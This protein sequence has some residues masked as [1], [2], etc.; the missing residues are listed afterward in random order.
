L[1]LSHPQ[2]LGRRLLF[3]F[4]KLSLIYLTLPTVELLITSPDNN[5]HTHSHHTHTHNRPRMAS[6]IQ[7]RQYYRFCDRNDDGSINE[8]SCYTPFWYTQ[9][10]C[11]SPY[12]PVLEGSND[13]VVLQTGVI[14][15]WSLFLGLVAFILL[16][17]L[18]GYMHAQRRMRKG[19]RPLAYHRVSCNPPAELEM[20][21]W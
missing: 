4:F 3:C 6:R 21:V 1:L 2:V 15:K 9:V 16:Y 11:I 17:L 10:R 14:V 18:L 5:T 20:Y 12:V 19:L 13:R 8:S 7:A